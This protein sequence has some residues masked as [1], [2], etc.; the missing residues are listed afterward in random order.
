MTRG[1]KNPA[2]EF[3]RRRR[4]RCEIIRP[5]SKFAYARGGIEHIRARVLKIKSMAGILGCL[6][7]RS[8]GQTRYENPGKTAA[9]AAATRKKAE[10]TGLTSVNHGGA[11]FFVC[12]T[13]TLQMQTRLRIK[14][15]PSFRPAGRPSLNAV[16][17]DLADERRGPFSYMEAIWARRG[18]GWITGVHGTCRCSAAAE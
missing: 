5:R 17:S 12:Q 3:P 13:H 15:T 6:N 9:A 7:L 11:M 14:N 18:W 8:G 16:R 2:C 4:R 10:Q 1:R